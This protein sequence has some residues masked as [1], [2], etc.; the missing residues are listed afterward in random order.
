MEVQSTRVDGKT[1]VVSVTVS[2][3]LAALTIDQVISKRRRL[4]TDMCTQV[5]E[6][7]IY[8]VRTAWHPELSA[9]LQSVHSGHRA[10][11][12]VEN[13]LNAI[14]VPF[15]ERHAEFYNTDMHLGGAINDAL[16]AASSLTHWST[17]LE[18][19]RTCNKKSRRRRGTLTACVCSCCLHR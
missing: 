17:G 3:N 8:S 5:T 15:C 18:E 4:V 12:V 13:R 6:K 2:V 7:I 9:A 1:M 19:L 10:H 16:A 11:E 14:L